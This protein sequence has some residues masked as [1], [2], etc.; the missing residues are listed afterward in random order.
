MIFRYSSTSGIFSGDGNNQDKLLLLNLIN[1]YSIFSLF[2]FIKILEIK[3]KFY[4]NIN[5][6]LQKFVELFSVD[7]LLILSFLKDNDLL[8][9]FPVKFFLNCIFNL[10][11][12]VL[13]QFIKPEDLLFFFSLEKQRMF[14]L[15]KKKKVNYLPFFFKFFRGHT[16]KNKFYNLKFLA[17]RKNLLNNLN[18]KQNLFIIGEV[19]DYYRGSITPFYKSNYSW[20]AST[21][22]KTDVE[23]ND[24]E[25]HNELITKNLIPNFYD[26]K[27][28]SIIFKLSN[29]T[30]PVTKKIKRTVRHLFFYQLHHFFSFQRY[31]GESTFSFN[32]F[33]QALFLITEFSF[34][35]LAEKKKHFFFSEKKHFFN[36]LIL[37]KNFGLFLKNRKIL[38]VF[39]CFS[40]TILNF[41]F[42]LSNLNLKNYS[43][44]YY[45][46]L[47][48]FYKISLLIK[49]IL[50][51]LT[52]RFFTQAKSSFLLKNLIKKE[53]KIFYFFSPVIIKTLFINLTFINKVR[54]YILKKSFI[55]SSFD[56]FLIQKYNYTFT[57]RLNTR[58]S[59]NKRLDITHYLLKKNKWFLTYKFI[60]FYLY[61]LIDWNYNLKLILNPKLTYSYIKLTSSFETSFNILKKNWAYNDN[62][63]IKELYF[64]LFVILEE[65]SL[66]LQKYISS[67][68]LGKEGLNMTSKFFLCSL[69]IYTYNLTVRDKKRDSLLLNDTIKL[70]GFFLGKW[71]YYR[72]QNKLSDDT[73]DGYYTLFKTSNAFNLTQKD[74]YLFNLA[75]LNSLGLE[76]S[77]K[78]DYFLKENNLKIT[79]NTI[80]GRMK[81]FF[82]FN[83]YKKKLKKRFIYQY[84]RNQVKSKKKFF[85]VK[86][87]KKIRLFNKNQKRKF[88]LNIKKI[89]LYRRTK[90]WCKRLTSNSTNILKAASF[91]KS[92]KAINYNKLIEVQVK[93]FTFFKNIKPFLKKETMYRKLT[94]KLKKKYVKV[95]DAI[96][97]NSFLLLYKQKILINEKKKNKTYYHFWFNLV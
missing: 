78:V 43:T 18:N 96:I 36:F 54:N 7:F 21:G 56:L 65:I 30:S 90:H 82:N 2:K 77:K 1:N 95:E 44:V 19:F 35:G 85:V 46:S 12:E 59:K 6:I 51:I 39:F 45:K 23:C 28:K 97:T 94:Y 24:I 33:Q 32:F 87:K 58:T 50:K 29:F 22:L 17:P 41:Y 14:A 11:I 5:K 72:Q 47:V 34:K 76:L 84:Y 38:L 70:S 83:F 4:L 13:I 55:Q 62:Y 42:T 16:D 8:K 61:Y 40:K 53:K 49:K 92:L 75:K 67:R 52:H 64:Y 25:L 88:I 71:F 10:L 68:V 66:N 60:F 80:K 63:N 26:N 48:I 20:F 31:L 27:F 3:F 69:F 89:M 93:A 86:E 91:R 74:T 37:F 57:K 15:K 73:F 79:T 9:L 81:H